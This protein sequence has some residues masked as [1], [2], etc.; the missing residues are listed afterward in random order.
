MSKIT[1]LLRK[2]NNFESE[3]STSINGSVYLCS[4]QIIKIGDP[5]NK[6]NHFTIIAK[7]HKKNYLVF[8]CTTKKSSKRKC[9]STNLFNI[10]KPSVGQSGVTTYILF[11]P[12]TFISPDDLNNKKV[13]CFKS[14]VIKEKFEEIMN[15]YREFILNSHKNIR[16]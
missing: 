1:E 14:K 10:T 2:Y 6:P 4:Y 9:F 13:S 7:K 15:S 8:P 5:I 12:T 11:S 16:G 3:Q